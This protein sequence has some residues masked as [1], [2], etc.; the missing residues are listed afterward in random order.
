MATERDLMKTG[1]PT[2]DQETSHGSAAPV[3]C[4]LVMKGG[5]TSGVIY[6]ELISQL[7]TRYRF[8]NIGGTSAGAI[9]A[10]A[11]AAAEY[12]RGDRYSK[13]S[14]LNFDSSWLTCA[15]TCFE[16]RVRLTKKKIAQQMA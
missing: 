14:S 2:G 10:A 15:L 16:N 5:I 7:S 6:P 13:V 9:A 12:G 3:M 1:V 11:C 8:K 4:D